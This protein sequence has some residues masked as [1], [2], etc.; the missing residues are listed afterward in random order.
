MHHAPKARPS[1]LPHAS[2]TVAASESPAPPAVCRHPKTFFRAHARPVCREHAPPPPHSE[3]REHLSHIIIR[4]GHSYPDAMCLPT[5]HLLFRE[6]LSSEIRHL[7]VSH[8]SV[9]F[10]PPNLVVEELEL[11]PPSARV[12]VHTQLARRAPHIGLL[13]AILGR[14]GAPAHTTG[15][16]PF[17]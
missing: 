14:C 2:Q 13:S 12:R 15:P 7:R 5:E 8:V 4:R 10:V 1:P 11:A 3:T 9:I 17:R 16:T 6:F